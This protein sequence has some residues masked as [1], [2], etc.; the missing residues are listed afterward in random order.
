VNGTPIKVGSSCCFAVVS[1]W[2]Q[3]VVRLKIRLKG[4]AGLDRMYE[5][6]PVW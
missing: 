6:C 5:A 2:L 3:N 4:K 1:V